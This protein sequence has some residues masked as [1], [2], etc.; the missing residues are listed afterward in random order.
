MALNYSSAS[1]SATSVNGVSA[2]AGGVLSATE[3]KTTR[4]AVAA[5]G[6][7]GLGLIAG[8]PTDLV[9]TVAPVLVAHR[10]RIEADP[11]VVAYYETRNQ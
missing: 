11:V 9:E 3:N 10:A 5:G 6:V 4:L 8:V 7:G 1:A 2:V